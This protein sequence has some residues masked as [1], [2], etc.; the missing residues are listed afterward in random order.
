MKNKIAVVVGGAGG[1]GLAICEVFLMA[2]WD[3]M[4]VDH[5]MSKLVEAS[6]KLS[7]VRGVR[8]DSRIH[9]VCTDMTDADSVALVCEKVKETS[10]LVEGLVFSTRFRY[11]HIKLDQNVKVELEKDIGLNIVCPTLLCHSL[12]EQSLVAKRTSFIFMSSTNRRFISHQP[13]S[14]HVTKGAIDQVVR[15]LAVEWASLGITV[16][17]I[18]PGVVAVANRPR[19]NSTL[20]DKTVERVIPLGRESQA[21]E[22]GELCLFLCSE[23]ARY[24]TG[25]TIQLDGGEHLRDHFSLIYENLP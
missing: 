18:S 1:I 12:V 11:Q 23:R 17:A 8:G 25:Q 16:N 22:I 24:L 19:S 6:E 5:E 2:N 15:Y 4:I 3:L 13:F 10:Q 20:F 21:S 7:G 14:Y 9:I